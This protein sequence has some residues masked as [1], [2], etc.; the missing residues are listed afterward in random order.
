MDECQSNYTEWKKPGKKEDILHESI[1]LKFI[2]LQTQKSTLVR[3]TGRQEG[4]V[5]KELEEAW[6]WWMCSLFWLWLQ[7]HACV[8]MPNL[9]K[10]YTLNMLYVYCVSIIPIEKHKKIL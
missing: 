8:L 9:I 6:V 1:H 4:E 2:E 10:L 3:G 7:F 5:A